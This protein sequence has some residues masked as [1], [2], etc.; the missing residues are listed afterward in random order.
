[1]VSFILFLA[2]NINECPSLEEFQD[3]HRDKE[4]IERQKEIAFG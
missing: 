1:M 3:L 2:L 4:L